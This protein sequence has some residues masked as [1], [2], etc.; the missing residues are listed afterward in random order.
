[1]PKHPRDIDGITDDI[2]KLLVF[3]G[4]TILKKYIVRGN[5]ESGDCYQI[6]F[7]NKLFVLSRAGPL[8][9][10]GWR[11]QLRCRDHTMWQYIKSYK[12]MTNLQI[13]I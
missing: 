8:L 11:D 13:C 3:P 6:Y 2:R 5:I 12:L 4:I 10:N 7:Y 1:M 9:L